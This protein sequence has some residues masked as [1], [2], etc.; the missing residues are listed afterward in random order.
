MHANDA[1]PH[2][3]SPPCRRDCTRRF[4][5]ACLLAILLVFAGAPAL[6]QTCATPVTFPDPVLPDMTGNTGWGEFGLPLVC[7]QFLAPGP[8]FVFRINFDGWTSTQMVLEGGAPGFNPVMY[9]TDGAQ[10][11]G[12]GACRAAGSVGVPILTADLPA[13]THWLIVTAG[14][15][16]PPDSQGAFMLSRDGQPPDGD[17]D[18]VYADGFE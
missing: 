2:R 4:R 5:P 17:A 15:F 12:V 13:G 3:P 9:V 18:L 11:C 6:A 14:E 8:S 10:A 7:G 16:D 1:R